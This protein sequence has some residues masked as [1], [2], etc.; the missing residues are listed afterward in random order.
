MPSLQVC[1]TQTVSESCQHWDYLFTNISQ[2]QPKCHLSSGSRVSGARNLLSADGREVLRQQESSTE[3]LLYLPDRRV[4]P[5]CAGSCSGRCVGRIVLRSGT[6]RSRRS[7]VRS[8]LLCSLRR[9][10]R[11]EIGYRKETQQLWSVSI[12]CDAATL[13]PYCSSKQ[14]CVFHFNMLNVLNYQ[15]HIWVRSSPMSKGIFR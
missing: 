12:T 5:S 10:T 4:R 3:S 6:R 14:S 2:S 1:C 15:C 13:Q 11:D 7:L 9:R 8:D